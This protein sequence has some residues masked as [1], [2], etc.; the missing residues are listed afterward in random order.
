MNI[1]LKVQLKL[2]FPN[3]LGDTVK[4]YLT[5]DLNWLIWLGPEKAAD[6]YLLNKAH[7]ELK[8]TQQI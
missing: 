2:N 1:A 6:T 8:Q 3:C 4:Q 5:G 7:R